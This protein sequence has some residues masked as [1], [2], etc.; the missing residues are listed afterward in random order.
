MRLSR[1]SKRTMLWLRT[2]TVMYFFVYELLI[3]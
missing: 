2:S 1:L 3:H